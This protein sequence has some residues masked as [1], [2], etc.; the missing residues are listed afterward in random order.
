VFVGLPWSAVSAH[1]LPYLFVY[2]GR[3]NQSSSPECPQVSSAYLPGALTGCWC[4]AFLVKKLFAHLIY[5]RGIGHVGIYKKL[6]FRLRSPNRHCRGCKKEQLCTSPETLVTG[7]D[8]VVLCAILVST[9]YA[10]LQLSEGQSACPH[11]HRYLGLLGHHQ[12]V[13][14]FLLQWQA[15]VCYCFPSHSLAKDSLFSSALLTLSLL[16]P[17]PRWLTSPQVTRALGVHC[18]H[19]V[20]WLSVLHLLASFAVPCCWTLLKQH[21]PVEKGS[22]QMD[23]LTFVSFWCL[24]SFVQ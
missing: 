1:F 19:Q 7:M 18:C 14:L 17:P 8:W 3:G 23:H 16:F 6:C 24:G 13:H 2:L 20:M 11:C 15:P 9:K 12:S 22:F 10:A 4:Q 21:L 5:K